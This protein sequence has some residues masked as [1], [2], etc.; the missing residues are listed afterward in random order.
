M[1]ALP[2]VRKLLFEGKNEEAT[3]LAGDKMMG[4]PF[5]VKSYQSLGDLRIFFN[6][7]SPATDYRRELDLDTALSVSLIPVTA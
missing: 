1:K 6:D 7:K 2:E 3:K 5:R 4:I